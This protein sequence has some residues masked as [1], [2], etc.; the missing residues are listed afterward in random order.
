MFVP[1]RAGMWQDW[2][3]DTVGVSLGVGAVLLVVWRRANRKRKVGG[4]TGMRGY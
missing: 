3:I 1:G 4:D 2:L